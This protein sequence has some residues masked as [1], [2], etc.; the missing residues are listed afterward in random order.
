MRNVVFGVVVAAVG[1]LAWLPPL[2]TRGACTAEF[3]ALS[4]QL[5]EARAQ[6]LTLSAAESYLA[7][8]G[9]R[10]QTL[11]DR[12]CESSALS[13]IVSCP[14]GA[15][16]VGVLPVKNGICHYYRDANVRFQLG[17]NRFAQLVRIQTDM[18]PYRKLKL[19]LLEYEVDLGK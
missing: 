9:L 7:A 12:Q 1:A 15:L 6:I 10:Y 2:F 19:P 18:N 4:E 14:G 5:Q 13:D 17:F 3:D 8:H 16:I 11:T